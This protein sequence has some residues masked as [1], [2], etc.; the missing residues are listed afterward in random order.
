MIL[1]IGCGTSQFGPGAPEF[2]LAER[3]WVRR[4]PTSTVLVALLV[5]LGAVIGVMFWERELPRPMA[6][7]A[8]AGRHCGASI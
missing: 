2:S 8:A 6:T 4:N 5:A 3:K 7:S 1:N